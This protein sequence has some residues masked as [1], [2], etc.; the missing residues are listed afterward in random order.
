MLHLSYATILAWPLLLR[1][2]LKVKPNRAPYIEEQEDGAEASDG[3]AEDAV[4]CQPVSNS[5]SPLSGK[6]TGKFADS[7]TPA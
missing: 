3:L 2:L 7:G 6:L 1:A 4:R 5:N